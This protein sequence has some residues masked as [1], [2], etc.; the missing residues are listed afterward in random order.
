MPF[1]Y[2]LKRDLGR[3]YIGSTTDIDRRLK[4]HGSGH[5]YS[6]KRMGR[7]ELVFSQK[8]AALF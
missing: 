3:Y 8:Y 6:T 1:V 5:M 4:Q 2:I 7:L